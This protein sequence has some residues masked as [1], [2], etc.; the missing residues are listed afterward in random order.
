MEYT[1]FLKLIVKLAQS[2]GF[3]IVD[4]DI[5][6]VLKNHNRLMV[7][8]LVNA[9]CNNSFYCIQSIIIQYLFSFKEF[10][11]I[12]VTN[13][14]KKD[15]SN[16]SSS[17]VKIIEILNSS[18]KICFISRL[19]PNIVV[20]F[21]EGVIQLSK[22][23]K[24]LV[25]QPKTFAVNICN[26]GEKIIY[27]I[28]GF[29]TNKRMRHSSTIIGYYIIMSLQSFKNLF[30]LIINRLPFFKYVLPIIIRVVSLFESARCKISNK[31]R[32]NTSA[33]YRGNNRYPINLRISSSL[34]Q[35][36]FFFSKY[37]LM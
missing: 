28:N 33:Q 10:N 5:N 8:R 15:F 1:E 14:L 24:H 31:R 34:E 18:E 12:K 37:E 23:N 35:K 22:L 20:H 7:K 26:L 36:H 25:T 11:I 19:I 4:S 32:G 13:V 21:Q 17:M 2:S 6:P 30:N 9:K 16:T 3:E 29:R 27:R